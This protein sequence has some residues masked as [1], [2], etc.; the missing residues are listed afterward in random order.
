MAITISGGHKPHSILA[1]VIILQTTGC[2]ITII[3]NGDPTLPS[4]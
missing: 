1:V 3:I 2:K 4:I